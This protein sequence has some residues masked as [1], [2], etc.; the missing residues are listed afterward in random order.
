MISLNLQVCS[1]RPYAALQFAEA[2]VNLRFDEDPKYSAYLGLFEPLCGPQ[3]QRPI[4]TDSLKVSTRLVLWVSCPR[5]AAVC[6]ARWCRTVLQAAKCQEAPA[7]TLQDYSSQ[8]WCGARAACAHGL[9]ECF[10]SAPVHAMTSLSCASAITSIWCLYGQVYV[11][12][13]LRRRAGC[14]HHM[15]RQRACVS[16]C[17]C[18]VHVY[19][20]ARGAHAV[21]GA[22]WADAWLGSVV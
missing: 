18:C 10:S 14:M 20:L 15:W 7:R 21:F 22:G 17:C 12:P 13:S 19:R 11:G 8:V 16:W 6:R 5:P 9:A 4:L 2:V 1:A 3:P